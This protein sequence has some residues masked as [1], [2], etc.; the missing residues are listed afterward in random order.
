MNMLR[1]IDIIHRVGDGIRYRIATAAVLLCGAI[2]IICAAGFAIAASYMWLA[3]E[4]PNYLAALCVA[5]GLVLAGGIVIV[6]ANVRHR[7]DNRDVK[8]AP[9]PDTARQA[10][11]AAERT[12]QAALSEAKNSPVLAVLTAL[13]LGVV[14]GLLRPKDDS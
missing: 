11:M 4:M 9:P 2:V 1:W 10:E 12:V 5:G 6:A 3:T 7:H 13:A 14:V 8:S